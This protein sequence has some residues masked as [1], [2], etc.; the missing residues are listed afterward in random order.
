MT[1]KLTFQIY[2]PLFYLFI[3]QETD[4]CIQLHR[5]EEKRKE[6]YVE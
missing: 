5:D 3:H 4:K 6:M 1:T 2:S